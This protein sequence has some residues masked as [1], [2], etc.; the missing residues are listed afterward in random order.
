[1]SGL[2][3]HRCV[4]IP[5]SRSARRIGISSHPGLMLDY[6]NGVLTGRVGRR[7]AGSTISPAP[8]QESAGNQDKAAVTGEPCAKCPAAS[9]IR[10]TA[11]TAIVENI[12][13]TAVPVRHRRRCARFDFRNLLLRLAIPLG[14]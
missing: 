5:L 8:S 13:P 11:A 3:R 2:S 4:S 6:G 14:R 1:V 12:A 9:A 10:A 7:T